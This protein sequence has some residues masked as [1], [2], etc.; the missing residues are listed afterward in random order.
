MTPVWNYLE[1]FDDDVL[2]TMTSSACLS[3]LSMDGYVGI[4]AVQSEIADAMLLHDIS[5]NQIQQAF[6]LGKDEHS[7]A[8]CQVAL[9]GVASGVCTC[10]PKGYTSCREIGKPVTNRAIRPLL[11]LWHMPH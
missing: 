10:K 11:S 9:V 2:S 3:V 6:E 5:L 8:A 7:M 4:P 1:G